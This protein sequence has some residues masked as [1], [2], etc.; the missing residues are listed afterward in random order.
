[1]CASDPIWAGEKNLAPSPL[2][3]RVK[4]DV[5]I[6]HVT[7]SRSCVSLVTIGAVEATILLRGANEYCPTFYVSLMNCVKFD[8]GDCPQKFILCGYLYLMDGCAL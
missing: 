8:V 5:Q 7:Q 3:S 2:P 1:V 6:R 4:F